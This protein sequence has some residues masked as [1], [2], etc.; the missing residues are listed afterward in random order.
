MRAKFYV[1]SKTEYS[2]NDTVSVVLQP[3]TT[4]SK[5][6]EAFW[7]WTP[8]GKLEMGIKAE[9]A[10]YFEVGKEYY[11]DFAPAAVPEPA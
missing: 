11:L 7:K 5:E 2:G 10:K 9:S 4:G 3:V 6:N 8:S 1:Y